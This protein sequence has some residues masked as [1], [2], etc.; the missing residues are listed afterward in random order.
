MSCV[1]V[2]ILF[3]TLVTHSHELASP[4]FPAF[5]QVDRSELRLGDV[6][7]YMTCL[8]HSYAHELRMFS[9][10][11]AE[12]FGSGACEARYSLGNSGRSHENINTATLPNHARNSPEDLFSARSSPLIFAQLESIPESEC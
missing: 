11:V 2:S 8:A 10:L 1:S 9:P 7:R 6:Q 3:L 4:D 12:L 5:P